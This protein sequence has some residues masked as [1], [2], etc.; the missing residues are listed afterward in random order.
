MDVEEISNLSIDE[1]FMLLFGLKPIE[2]DPTEFVTEELTTELFVTLVEPFLKENHPTGIFRNLFPYLVDSISRTIPFTRLVTCIQELNER[3]EPDN[4]Y[5]ILKR[6]EECTGRDFLIAFLDKVPEKSFLKILDA[7]VT[8]NIPIP[9][10]LPNDESHSKKGL[11]V[12]NGMRDIITAHKYHLFLSVNQE[13]T[14]IE[15]PF[16][17]QLYKNF[18]NHREDIPGIC[19]PNSIDISFHAASENH[20]RPPLAISE[21]YYDKPSS[22][23]FLRTVKALSKFSF[24]I[25]IHVSSNDFDGCEPKDQLNLTLDNIS[26]ESYCNHKRKILVLFWGFKAQ[27]FGKLKERMEKVLAEKFI[28]D[29]FW[30]MEVIPRNKK[31]I[32]ER[33]KKD[34]F[35]KLMDTKKPWL[36]WTSILDDRRDDN[37]FLSE[38]YFALSMERVQFSCR[39]DIFFASHCFTEMERLRDKGRLKASDDLESYKTQSEIYSEIKTY[40]EKQKNLANCK[41]I[42]ILLDFAKVIKKKE[43]KYMRKFANQ[44]DIYFKKSLEYLTQTDFNLSQGGQIGIQRKELRQK[45]EDHDITIHDFWREFVILSQIMPE[46]GGGCLSVLEKLYDVNYRQLE[47]AYE[48]WI[49]EGE[50]IQILEGVSLRTLNSN[51]LSDVLNRVMSDSKRQLIVLSVIGLESSGKSTLLN[52]LFRCGFSTSAGRCT[53]GA[54]MSY[55]HTTHNGKGLDLLIIDSEGMGSTVAKYISRRADFDKKMTLLGIMCSQILILNIKGLTGGISDTL[56]VSSYHID[57]LSNR[58]SKPRISFVLRDM[59][60]TKDAQRPAFHDIREGLK[61]MFNEI[62]N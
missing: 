45:I 48:I 1:F 61:K 7:I 37:D 62:P 51:F 16:S 33:I 38:S 41:P 32:F 43:I 11:K 25:V 14:G 22:P 28:D 18:S 55:R 47:E 10:F 58:G 29:E 34:S 15:K 4:L 24:Y 35:Q 17:K 6:F 27:I 60:D 50:A 54:Y 56:E 42:P 53:K 2:L 3:D 9:I 21:V 39:A 5:K 31:I 36:N 19:N 44:V 40:Q 23:I 12:L 13:N 20:T 46:T 57:A 52:Y 26:T 8:A 59:K 49:R 30:C